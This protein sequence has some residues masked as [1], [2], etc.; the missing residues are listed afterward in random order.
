[1]LG[2]DRRRKWII[3]GIAAVATFAVLLYLSATDWFKSPAL[4]PGLV[5]VLCFGVAVAVTALVAGLTRRNV[6]YSCLVMAGLSSVLQFFLTP[7]LQ[8]PKWASWL[9]LLL[10]A[11]LASAVAVGVGWLLGGLDKEQA[12]RAAV[13][14]GL[15]CGAVI[16]FDVVL[17]TIPSYA[18][19]VNG[20]ILATIGAGTPN[21]AGSFWQ[22]FIDTA[23]HLTLPTLSIML[24][25]SPPTGTPRLDAGGDGPGL[26]ADGP[27]QGADRAHRGDAARLPQRADPGDHLAAVDFGAL[28]GGAIITET[29]F[30]WKDGSD[31]RPGPAD[32]RPEPGDGL[33]HHH[34]DPGDHVQHVRRHRLRL[35]RPTDPPVLTPRLGRSRGEPMADLDTRSRR[36]GHRAAGG[37]GRARVHDQGEDAAAAGD[38]AVL[39]PPRGDGRPIVFLFVVFLAFTATLRRHPRLVGPELRGLGVVVDGGRMTRRTVS[40]R[41]STATACR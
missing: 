23:T 40:P 30:G 4:G 3:R 14:T 34:G 11:L 22:R 32:H 19:M 20:R 37:A 31:V 38:P 41:S 26:R 35:P 17:R 33:L 9:N 7:F 24:I 12:V 2:G 5:T 8:N 36:F 1:V 15:G 13:L 6:L 39:P 21:F 29:V 10:L 27:G 25:R 18:R 16:V 28:I